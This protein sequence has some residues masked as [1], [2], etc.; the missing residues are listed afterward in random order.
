MYSR[1]NPPFIIGSLLLLILLIITFV[2]P[3]LPFID[4]ELTQTGYL[5]SEDKK[6][7]PPPFSPGEEFSFGSDRKGRDL[8]SVLVLGA[9]ETLMVVIIISFLCFLFSLPFGAL[10]AQSKKIDFLLTCWNVLFSKVP[11]LFFI[12]LVASNPFFIFSEY[13]WYWM[14]G[15]ILVL[16]VGRISHLFQQQI[17]DIKHSEVILS[18]ISV[19]TSP[20]KLFKRYYL[21]ELFPQLCFS[22]I[23]QLGKTMFLLGQLGIFSI[24]ISQ[25]F[26]MTGGI[27]GGP[28]EYE[29]RNASLA[30]PTL[31]EGIL[32]DIHQAPWIP[33]WTSGFIAL[34]MLAFNF[35]GEGLR[36]QMKLKRRR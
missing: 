32:I 24:F 3:F 9:K 18:G 15:L 25:E 34:T 14:L 36:I 33:F 35:F 16:E 4:K 26:V 5:Y 13:R 27:I 19:G 29:M 12:I 6:I 21:P 2:G 30:W 11:P 22:F 23:L 10:A 1:K 8:L 7:L 31:L 28:P 17:L 20:F